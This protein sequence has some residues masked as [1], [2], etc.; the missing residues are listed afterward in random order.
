MKMS[1]RLF[2]MLLGALFAI[3][4]LLFATNLFHSNKSNK[5]SGVKHPN[6]DSAALS[7]SN[8]M[9]PAVTSI[10]NDAKTIQSHFQDIC[11]KRK[12]RTNKK[13]SCQRPSLGLLTPVLPSNS[14][15]DDDS[16]VYIDATLYVRHAAPYLVHLLDESH[17]KVPI[18]TKEAIHKGVTTMNHDFVT[19]FVRTLTERHV[20]RGFVL[21]LDASTGIHTLISALLGYRVIAF[22]ASSK[23]SQLLSKTVTMNKI[24][25]SVTL[26]Q[27]SLSDGVY[28]LLEVIEKQEE[29]I[30]PAIQSATTSTSSSTGSIICLDTLVPY[31]NAVTKYDNLPKVVT[32]MK[33]G[34][35]APLIIRGG[36][37]FFSIY[38]VHTIIFEINLNEWINVGCPPVEV[39][40]AL[41]KLSYVMTSRDKSLVRNVY[42]FKR[43]YDEHLSMRDKSR[44]ID[45]VFTLR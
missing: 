12:V 42:E 5:K 6:F 41:F 16:V 14:K 13:N 39:A 32:L 18:C 21:D 37:N 27:N 33:M 31:L 26:F 8:P 23:T 4:Y 43:W 15:C 19:F 2:L 22:E 25:S 10:S 20:G 17:Q 36:I 24:E 29:N 1:A 9:L 44:T 7:S 35:N 28:N 3:S 45:V 34:I 40:D 11:S 30:S 38:K